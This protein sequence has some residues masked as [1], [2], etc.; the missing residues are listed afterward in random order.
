MKSM[1][2]D[3]ARQKDRIYDLAFSSFIR[4]FRIEK[5]E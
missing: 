4:D 2:R 5:M 1:V 3:I